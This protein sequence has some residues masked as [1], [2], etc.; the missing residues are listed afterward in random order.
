M[1]FFTKMYVEYYNT[2]AIFFLLFLPKL[3][4]ILILSII[5]IFCFG[6]DYFGKKE[7]KIQDKRKAYF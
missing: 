2:V 3:C 6:E 5:S 1:Y 7:E 4:I